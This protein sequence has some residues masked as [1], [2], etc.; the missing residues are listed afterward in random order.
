MFG[1]PSTVEI[2]V[3]D[4]GD[5]QILSLFKQFWGSSTSFSLLKQGR[6]LH[7]SHSGPYHHLDLLASF[8]FLDFL[9]GMLSVFS[10]MAQ[11]TTFQAWQ[12]SLF[13]AYCFLYLP[14]IKSLNPIE[15]AYWIHISVYH[16]IICHY[17]SYLFQS[18]NQMNKN[19]A[20][21]YL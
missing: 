20:W 13:P 15:V 5:L 6:S 9:I 12:A 19:Q 8:E 1:I 17:I 21:K 10:L 14:L 3:D 18:S 4:S 11:W 7:L 16:I 2:K